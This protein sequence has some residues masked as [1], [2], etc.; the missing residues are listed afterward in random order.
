MTVERYQQN[1]QDVASLAQAFDADALKMAGV[2]TANNTELG[3]P[4]AA[5]HINGVYLPR[6]RGV[7]AM[8]FDL[9][10]VEVNK[11]PQGTLRGRN[12]VAGTLNIIT[13]RP[14]LGEVDGYVEAGFGDYDSRTVEGAI[15]LPAGEQFA[16]R[17]A[18][19]YDAHDSYF[20]NAGL[21]D[22]TPAGE[23][24]ERAGRLSALWESSEELSLFSSATTSRKAERAIPAR[25]CSARSSR[26]SSSTTSTRDYRDLD[27]SQINAENDNIAF[28]GRDLTA[29]D[30]A[31]NPDGVNYDN[32]GNVF[33]LTR[34]ESQVHELR[35]LSSSEASTTW[36]GG[37]FYFKEDQEVGFFST[38]DN[39]GVPA[40]GSEESQG[41]Q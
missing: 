23:E 3:D 6:P 18:G 36:T 12:A 27:F 39:A 7:S 19:L 38:T 16:L 8:F 4:S 26:A 10:R 9:E 31:S 5:T 22:L 15:N 28:P 33:W 32:R 29:F 30:A 14:Q 41:S 35:L 2:G 1:L 11:G 34:S 25:T 40:I 21:A 20:R 17:L 37:V 24:D 13:K